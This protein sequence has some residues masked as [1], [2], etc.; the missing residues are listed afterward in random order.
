MAYVNDTVTYTAHCCLGN[1]CGQQWRRL[2]RFATVEDA[3]GEIIRHLRMSSKHN[4]TETDAI[5]QVRQYTKMGSDGCCVLATSNEAMRVVTSSSSKSYAVRS[6]SRSGPHEAYAPNTRLIPADSI[7]DPVTY[8]VQ[9][10]TYVEE[11]ATVIEQSIQALD[12]IRGFFTTQAGSTTLD[13]APQLIVDFKYIQGALLSH[14]NQLRGVVLN[15]RK[16]TI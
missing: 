3:R 16:Y 8:P 6:R 7:C 5:I 10:P 1:I 11:D 15:M 14:V 13:E 12:A 4:M 9:L 2:G